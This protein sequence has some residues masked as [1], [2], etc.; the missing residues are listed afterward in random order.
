MS[1]NVTDINSLLR[2]SVVLS[3]EEPLPCTGFP[4]CC[5]WHLTWNSTTIIRSI[6]STYCSKSTDVK[7]LNLVFTTP[8]ATSKVAIDVEPPQKKSSS[9][10]SKAVLRMLSLLE[11]FPVVVLRSL[12]N[13]NFEK[14]VCRKTFLKKNIQF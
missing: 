5:E 12:Y 1:V 14:L 2:N 11:L 9:L 10:L 4:R 3:V 8:I 6:G 7:A 13:K